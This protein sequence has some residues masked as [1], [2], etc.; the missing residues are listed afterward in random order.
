[1]QN[2]VGSIA[3]MCFTGRSADDVSGAIIRIMIMLILVA[4][5]IVI[6]VAVLGVILNRSVSGKMRDV[7]GDLTDT[8]SYFD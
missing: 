3:G 8:I 2:S 7:S 6:V 1:M 5:V 4:I